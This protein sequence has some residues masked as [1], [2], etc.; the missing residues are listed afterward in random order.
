[1]PSTAHSG[2]RLGAADDLDAI[3]VG[4][5][6]VCEVVHYRTIARGPASATSLVESGSVPPAVVGP[7]TAGASMKKGSL[8]QTRVFAYHTM[9]VSRAV[10]PGVPLV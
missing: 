9:T 2:K 7:D 6:E 3:E 8:H 4:E 10:A 1:M 5:R